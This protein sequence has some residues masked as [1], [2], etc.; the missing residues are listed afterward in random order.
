LGTSFLSEGEYKCG[1]FSAAQKATV[2]PRQI[3]EASEREI[4]YKFRS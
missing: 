2:G 1:P 3:K 4:C